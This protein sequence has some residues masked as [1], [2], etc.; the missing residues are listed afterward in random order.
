MIGEREMCNL[1]HTHTRDEEYRN[2]AYRLT[3]TRDL[4]LPHQ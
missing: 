1:T 3:A 4:A 2:I